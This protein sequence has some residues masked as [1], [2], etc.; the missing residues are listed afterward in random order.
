MHLSIFLFCLFNFFTIMTFT[1]GNYSRNKRQ[2]PKILIYL[3]N[4][5]NQISPPPIIKHVLAAQNDFGILKNTWDKFPND[6]VKMRTSLYLSLYSEQSSSPLSKPPLIQ[7][8]PQWTLGAVSH[9]G[10]SITIWS[11]IN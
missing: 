6:P 8:G 1:F 5:I 9:S 7:K 2:R 11:A 10:S 4:Q 3:S